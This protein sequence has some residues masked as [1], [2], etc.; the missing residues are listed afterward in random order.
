MGVGGTFE[1][2]AI[3]SKKALLRVLGSP[4]PDPTLDGI[5]RELLDHYEL[6]SQ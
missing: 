4:N 3:L 5:E 1:K 6:T 2:A